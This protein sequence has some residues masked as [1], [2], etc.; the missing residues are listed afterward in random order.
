RDGEGAL[1][2]QAHG[3]AGQGGGK[4]GRAEPAQHAP[5][6]T[7]TRHANRESSC[8]AEGAPPTLARGVW[9]AHQTVDHLG[10]PFERPESM[11]PVVANLHITVEGPTQVV[12]R[13]VRCRSEEH[14]SELQSLTNLVCRLLLEKKKEHLTRLLAPQQHKARRADV[15]VSERRHLLRAHHHDLHAALPPSSAAAHPRLTHQPV[16]HRR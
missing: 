2:V 1:Y 10:R 11:I 15:R 12:N 8:G 3:R 13:L 9:T 16:V 7:P 5:A 14:T 6:D 4:G